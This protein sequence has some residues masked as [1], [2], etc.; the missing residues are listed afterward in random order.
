MLARDM[1]VRAELEAD[2]SLFEAYNPRMEDVHRVNSAA[3]RAIIEQ[4]GWPDERLVG[5]EGAE[6]AWLVV[7]HAIAEPSFMRHCRILLDEA[8]SSGRVPR[9][10]FAYLDDRIRVFEG[11][12]QR[13]GTQFDLKPDGPQINP[14]EDPVQVDTWRRDAG[15]GPITEV[16]ST[17]RLGR[18][19]SIEAYAANQA[20][21]HLWHRK[22]GWVL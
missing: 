16:L 15:L 7:Q 13:F 3:L 9:W 1:Q 18:L 19:P 12:A 2:G 8:S 5:S 10:Q 11:K 20:A 6:A 21:G 14:L 4:H 17:A 22:V